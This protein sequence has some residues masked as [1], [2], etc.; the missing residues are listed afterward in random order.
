MSYAGPRENP[1]EVFFFGI[2]AK[3]IRRYLAV[4]KWVY[5]TGSAGGGSSGRRESRVSL[6]PLDSLRCSGS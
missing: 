3:V 2:R 5:L 4:R 1:I 6:A